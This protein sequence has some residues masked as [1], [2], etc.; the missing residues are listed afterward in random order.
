MY[1]II[2][3][4]HYNR[5]DYTKRVLDSLSK[6]EGIEDYIFLGFCEPGFPEVEQ[7]IRNINFCEAFITINQ[8]KLG[9]NI[10]IFKSLISGYLLDATEVLVIEDDV[11]VSRDSLKKYEEWTETGIDTFS[12]CMY[13]RVLEKDYRPE[14]RDLVLKRQQ[15]VPWGV[16]YHRWSFMKMVEWNCFGKSDSFSW[17]VEVDRN[18]QKRGYQHAYTFLSRSQNIGRLGGIHVPSPEWHDQHHHLPFWAGDLDERED[19]QRN[20]GKQ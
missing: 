19:N 15:F 16:A 17:D 3:S 11:M 13:N 14:Q 10:N 12:F 2:V 7:Q 6:A 9:C 1:K 8:E 5:P 4:P 18:C 20:A